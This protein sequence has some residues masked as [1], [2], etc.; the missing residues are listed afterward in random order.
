MPLSRV[1]G[2]KGTIEYLAWELVSSTSDAVIEWIGQMICCRLHGH[3]LLES[4]KVQFALKFVS[5][6]CWYS[7]FIYIYIYF[8]LTIYFVR[9]VSFF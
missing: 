1:F 9:G 4:S 3:S 5:F 2:S 8:L 6:S 7:L